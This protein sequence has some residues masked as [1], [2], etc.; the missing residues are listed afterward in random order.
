MSLWTTVSTLGVDQTDDSS[1]KLGIQLSNILA[2]ILI[3]LTCVLFALYYYWYG[4]G[5][6]T[7]AIPVTA[8]FPITTLVMNRL[9][10]IN[11]SRLWIAIYIPIVVLS[12]SVYSKNLY[13]NRQQDL[14]YFTFRFIILASCVFPPILFSLRE[15]LRVIASYALGLTLLLCFDPIH[16]LFDVPFPYRQIQPATYQ[17]TNVVVFITYCI[18]MMAVTFLKYL[19]EKNERSNQRLIQQLNI[20]NDELREK[21]EEIEEQAMELMSQSDALNY[22]Q[23]RLQEAYSQIEKQKSQLHEANEQLESELVKR[24]QE[25]THTNT[26]LIKHNNELRQFSYT[27]S[28]NLRGP[29]AS[30]LGLTSLLNDKHLDP[31]NRE[32]IDHIRNST[33][34]FDSIIK[35]LN[36]IIDIRHDIFRIRQRISLQRELRDV[37]GMLQREIDQHAVTISG[38]YNDVYLYSVQPLIAS[39][40]YN[41]VSNAIKYRSPDRAPAI[42]IEFAQT[43][44]QYIL[45][46]TDNGLGINLAQ[47][48]DN[49]FRLYKRFHQH[50]EGKGLGLYLVKLQA[51]ALGGTVEVESELN[52]FT[53]FIVSI[54]IPQ[55]V[56]QQVLVD[57]PAATLFYDAVLN[58]TGVSWKRPVDSNE[59]RTIYRRGVEF[60][61]SYH[62]PNWI[63]DMRLQGSVS[64]EDEGWLLEKVIPDAFAVGL[65]LVAGITTH[66][67]QSTRMQEYLRSIQLRLVNSGVQINYFNNL[68][69]ARHWIMHQQAQA[70][71]QQSNST[72][73]H[74]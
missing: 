40:L 44:S 66:D 10:F 19:Q 61:R 62:T 41:L 70:L 47:H 4:G 29:V 23:T 21:N 49:L 34:R 51:E 36:K 46:V 8:I 11:F 14:D 26:E 5:F 42:A 15:R 55:N 27:I 28:H 12:I 25:L 35:D 54:R 38:N 32:I 60:M 37:T 68:P 18:L 57:E 2:L 24:N 22:N 31:S 72:T 13:Y 58:A 59:Y 69:D 56:E 7:Y 65:R 17:F 6:I 9:G 33:L 74:A 20:A 48:R 43:E 45:T 3:G 1:R 67:I 71:S 53:R 52:R 30:L 64:L 39:I 16:A 73:S 50:T 63:A